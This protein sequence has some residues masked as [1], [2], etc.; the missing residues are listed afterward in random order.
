MHSTVNTGYRATWWCVLRVELRCSLSSFDRCG[1]SDSQLISRHLHLDLCLWSCILLNFCLAFP[2]IQM[3]I[4]IPVLYQWHWGKHSLVY[5]K[6]CCHGTISTV[7]LAAE[8][9]NWSRHLAFSKFT[10]QDSFRG[11]DTYKYL[12]P[13]EVIG[14]PFLGLDGDGDGSESPSDY[15]IFHSISFQFPAISRPWPADLWKCAQSHHP[16]LTRDATMTC[17]QLDNASHAITA[18]ER[19]FPGFLYVK[20]NFFL[21]VQDTSWIKNSM[22]FFA[23]RFSTFIMISCFS[24]LN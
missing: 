3:R 9:C 12:S 6:Y 22:W 2:Q 21:S 14:I 4:V 20:Y 15:P 10:V 18:W 8:E 16:A 24:P 7:S 1:S 11:W 17:D 19:I 5:Q 23:E 13:T